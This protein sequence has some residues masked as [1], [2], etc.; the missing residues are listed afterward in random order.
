MLLRPGYRA[1]VSRRRPVTLT[2]RPARWPS[3]PE[4]KRQPERLFRFR[5][6]SS[7]LPR[8]HASVPPVAWRSLNGKVL[9]R[10]VPWPAQRT[11]EPAVRRTEAPAAPRTVRLSRQTARGARRSSNLLEQSSRQLP[12]HGLPVLADAGGVAFAAV[13]L[14]RVKAGKPGRVPAPA[15]APGAWVASRSAWRQA[16]C[17]RCP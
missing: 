15:G 5:A 14:I 8:G 3:P 10:S 7:P 17:P 1:S 6:L 9:P 11:G 13:R 4:R 12:S 2:S 16:P